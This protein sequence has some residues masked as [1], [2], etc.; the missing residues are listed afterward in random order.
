MAR[1]K[2][3]RKKPLN[4]NKLC[5]EWL[6]NL[7]WVVEMVEYRIPHTF[8]TKDH[9]GFIDMLA[10]KGNRIIGVQATSPVN[11]AARVKKS[12]ASE[13]FDVFT[14]AASGFYVVGITNEDV[15]CLG[16]TRDF[17]VEVTSP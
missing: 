2:K 1:K 10:Y 8:I 17:E 7:G 12:R 4:C 13:N 16:V 9:L 3:P 14:V 5:K 15:K 6:Q 11:M